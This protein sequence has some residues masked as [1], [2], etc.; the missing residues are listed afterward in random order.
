MCWRSGSG[1]YGR[2]S[3]TFCHRL[4]L[5]HRGLCC[6]CTERADTYTFRT[7]GLLFQILFVTAQSD[8]IPSIQSQ[9]PL[10]Q[11]SLAILWVVYLFFTNLPHNFSTLL[12]NPQVST[13]W[14]SKL[15]VNR[16][17]LCTVG[18]LS[19]PF[20][21]CIRVVT[22]P[23]MALGCT[24]AGN[25][26]RQSPWRPL[27]RRR[28]VGSGPLNDAGRWPLPPHILWSLSFIA[29]CLAIKPGKCPFAIHA[30]IFWSLNAFGTLP[31][32]MGDVGRSKGADHWFIHILSLF[33]LAY[34]MSHS[35]PLPETAQ[36]T[37]KQR[38][39]LLSI[40]RHRKA[41][42]WIS[43]DAIYGRLQISYY[44]CK[45]CAVHQTIR[46]RRILSLLPPTANRLR[47]ID[48]DA[49]SR[50]V[51][52]RLGRWAKEERKTL[53]NNKETWKRNLWS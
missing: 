17:A 28:Q 14:N 40:S 4:K 36:P 41:A 1:F 30:P 50:L 19:V 9:T 49:W 11:K 35:L 2:D 45:W 20:K 15:R 23:L 3:C 46:I 24:P 5:I 16:N 53:E 37:E 22:V 27:P 39:V 33:W 34:S 8:I 48:R 18:Y 12:F 26:R 38:H 25:G 43:G 32:S 6:G 10:P 13:S 29:F 31:G 44:L 7:V 52:W 51:S 47:F 21:H 42:Y